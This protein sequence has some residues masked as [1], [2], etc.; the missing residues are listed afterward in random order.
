MSPPG[1]RRAAPATGTATASNAAA[2][3]P[4]VLR[5]GDTG[6]PLAMEA[7]AQA[8]SP[9]EGWARARAQRSY[10]RRLELAVR[11]QLRWQRIAILWPPSATCPAEAD[12]EWLV[13]VLVQ[14]ITVGMH[15]AEVRDAAAV[16]PLDAHAADAA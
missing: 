14:V 13:E 5:D 4:Q 7:A 6:S 8:V 9:A 11:S 1:K 3:K 16:Q 2:A 15:A 12:G 10:L